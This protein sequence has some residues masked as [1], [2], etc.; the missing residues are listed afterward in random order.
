MLPHMV[1]LA[2][3]NDLEFDGNQAGL[4][5]LITGIDAPGDE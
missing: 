4:S 2:H 1:M 5:S 3:H